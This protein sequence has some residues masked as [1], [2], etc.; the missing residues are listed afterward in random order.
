MAFVNELHRRL[1]PRSS[2]AQFTTGLPVVQLLDRRRGVCRVV[3][4]IAAMAV[5]RCS[6][7]N[8]RAA[9][10]SRLFFAVFAVSARQLFLAQ[11]CRRAIGRTRSREDVL[12]EE[13]VAA[14]HH[15]RAGA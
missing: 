11:P 9:P 10:S 13:S 14:H 5:R 1:A 6:S 4:A 3:L 7:S 15:H 12:R 2:E 8:G